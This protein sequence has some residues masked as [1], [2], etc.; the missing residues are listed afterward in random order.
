MCV[1]STCFDGFCLSDSFT[2]IAVFSSPLY[3][4]YCIN[5]SILSITFTVLFIKSNFNT[6]GNSILP[7]SL[8]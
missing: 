6:S 2:E 4:Q 7:L 1:A 5:G 3:L 8:K